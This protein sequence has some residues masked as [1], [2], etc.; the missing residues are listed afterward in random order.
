MK[1]SQIEKEKRT[2]ERM[3][4]LY[5]RKREKN[6]ALCSQC[7]ALIGYAHQRLDRC[8]FGEEK[9]SCKRCPVHCY[10]PAEREQVR[11]IMRYVG[12][13]MIYLSPADFIRHLFNK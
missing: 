2:I 11:Q 3:I 1:L 5:C 8:P 13:R 10:K 7:E 4:R 6:S 12:P 9:T